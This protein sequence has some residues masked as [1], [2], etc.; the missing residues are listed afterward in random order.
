M[1]NIDHNVFTFISYPLLEDQH[2]LKNG[3]ISVKRKGT[4]ISGSEYASVSKVRMSLGYEVKNYIQLVHCIAE[5]GYK[6][7]SYNLLFRGQEKDYKNNKGK[8]TLYPSIYRPGEGRVR[9]SSKI[10]LERFNTMEN[11]IGILRKNRAKINLYKGLSDYQEYQIALLQHYELELTPFLDLTNSLL[12]ATSFALLNSNEG[13]LYVLGM[14]H[15]YGSISLFVDYSMR[16]VNL[17]NVSPP[18]AIV[19]S[20]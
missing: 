19:N 14:P 6:N 2:S 17:Q 3:R 7:N 10:L 5:I 1:F 8:T 15:T 12:V 16:I 20:G 11:S 4:I 9:L 18:E 13:Y